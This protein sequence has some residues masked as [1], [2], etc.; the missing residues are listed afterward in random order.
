MTPSG[1]SS[2]EVLSNPACQV[3]APSDPRGALRSTRAGTWPYSF[4]Q[5]H[6]HPLPNRVG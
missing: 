2:Q 4:K 6:S 5:P 1:S 3:P